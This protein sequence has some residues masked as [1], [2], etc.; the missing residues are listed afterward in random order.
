MSSSDDEF[1]AAVTQSAKMIRRKKKLRPTESSSVKPIKDP[2]K[3]ALKVPSNFNLQLSLSGSD[4]LSGSSKPVSPKKLHEKPI[5]KIAKKLDLSSDS[6]DVDELENFFEKLKTPSKPLRPLTP[7][8]NFIVPDDYES[9]NEFD[10]TTVVNSSPNY[11]SEDS[12]DEKNELESTVVEI[13][14]SDEIFDNL[15]PAKKTPRSRNKK[16][17]RMPIDMTPENMHKIIRK[18]LK[19]RSSSSRG[20][21]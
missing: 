11:S 5:E 19:S 20:Q 14:S 4:S 17:P 9:D 3:S 6:D 21:K 12:A 1:F 2:S 16:L 15:T 18:T 13:S 10:K 8:D 7:V